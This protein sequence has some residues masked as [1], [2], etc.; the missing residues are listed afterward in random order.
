[1]IESVNSKSRQ[2]YK[3]WS[4]NR[5]L[6]PHSEGRR[7]VRRGYWVYIRKAG[8]REKQR[9]CS[10]RDFFRDRIFPG[11]FSLRISVGEFQSYSLQVN[12]HLVHLK[13]RVSDSSADRSCL[14]HQ[15]ALLFPHSGHFAFV[16]G[17]PE[18]CSPSRTT[19]SCS[20]IFALETNAFA[21]SS[22]GSLWPH[23]LHSK[24]PFL[25]SIILLH[26]GQNRINITFCIVY[27]FIMVKSQFGD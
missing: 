1:M 21:F 19:I 2:L 5:W 3:A 25:G 24:L 15:Y 16:V 13:K 18:T 14:N 26:L 4:E 12:P 6:F 23:F 17:R 20:S 8:L 10:S 22:I 27:H 7:Q 9:L 11:N